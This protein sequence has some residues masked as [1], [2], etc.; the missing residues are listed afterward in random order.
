M[1]D[2]AQKQVF[3]L[4]LPELDPDPDLVV[5]FLDAP[6]F[7]LPRHNFSAQLLA[8]L[9][10]KLLRAPFIWLRCGSIVPPLNHPYAVLRHGPRSFTIRVRSR[11]EIVCVSHLKACTEGDATPG[12]P[13]HHG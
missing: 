13:R 7:S 12:S 1:H 9:P 5:K 11:D 8:E 3:F 10:D 6:A 4:K 2:I